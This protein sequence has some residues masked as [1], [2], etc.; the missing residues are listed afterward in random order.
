MNLGNCWQEFRGRCGVRGLSPR[1]LGVMVAVCL[2]L[3]RI[4]RAK[5]EGQTAYRYESYQEDGGRIHVETHSALFELALKPGVLSLKGEMVYD[6]ISGATP[7]GAAEPSKYRYLTGAD[8][9]I[10]GFEVPILGNTNSTQVA[11]SDLKPD[12]RRGISL[13]APVTIGHHQFRPQASFSEESDYNSRSAGLNYAFDF[14]EKNS[15]LN[16]GWSHAWDRSH[17]DFGRWQN[18][19]TDDFIVGLTQ[20]LGPRTVLSL[21]F[22][23]GKSRG[24]L[25]DPYR[26]IVAANDPQVDADNPAGVSE[27]RPGGRERYIAF[28]SLTQYISPMHAS[29]ESSYRFF[30]DTFGIDAHTVDVAWHQKLGARVVLSP[31]VRY[32]RQ[33]AASFYYDMLPDI[34]NRPQYFSPDYRLSELNSWTVGA[35]ISVRATD[36]F[37]VDVSYK[38]YLMQGLDG[39]TSET[40]YPS[41]HVITAGARLLF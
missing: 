38:R 20:L 6:A 31:M 37:T 13:E 14:N 7:N 28:T 12:Y 30:H 16:L 2:C 18:K 32:Y 22:T 23:Y 5:A 19:E 17:D 35:G 25:N 8:L 11:M 33:S 9:G 4:Q 15:T 34:N 3:V 29:L 36:W 21:N 27:Q 1:A 40:A 10:P 24:Y 39:V 41:A 26:F